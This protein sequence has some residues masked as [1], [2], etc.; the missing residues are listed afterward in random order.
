MKRDAAEAGLPDREE[1]GSAAR[2]DDTPQVERA[3][4]WS[5]P[6]LGRGWAP[7]AGT[8]RLMGVASVCVFARAGFGGGGDGARGGG[9][10]A[11]G[12]GG[13]RGERA[14]EE[15]CAAAAGDRGVVQQPSKAG[16]DRQQRGAVCGESP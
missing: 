4:S 9:G 16:G 1:G 8:Q 15:G 6:Q 2:V 14:T 3:L 5:T 12:A 13:E 10:G 11:G 7:R